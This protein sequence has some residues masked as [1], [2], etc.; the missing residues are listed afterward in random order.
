MHGCMLGYKIGSVIYLSS[1]PRTGQVKR[2][3]YKAATVNATLHG[4]MNRSGGE[5]ELKGY[6]L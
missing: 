4:D 1:V 2:S 6:W 5:S 3:R